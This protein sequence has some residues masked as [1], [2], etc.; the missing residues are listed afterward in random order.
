MKKPHG[1][2]ARDGDGMAYFLSE[3]PTFRKWGRVWVGEDFVRLDEVLCDHINI[4]PGECKPV[5]LTT[6]APE[7]ER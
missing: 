6:E 5:W 3:Q 4:K 1:W 2:V 7:E